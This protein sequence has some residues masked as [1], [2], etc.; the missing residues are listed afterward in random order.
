MARKDGSN[1]VTVAGHLS[2]PIPKLTQGENVTPV[3]G[4][5]N[6]AVACRGAAGA[7]GAF[8]VGDTVSVRY[9]VEKSNGDPWMLSE[10]S[11]GRIMIS[12][13]TFNYQRVIPEKNDV[14]SRSVENDDGSFTY[15]FADPLPAVYAAPYNDTASFGLDDGELTGQ[16]LLNGTYTVGMYMAWA[17]TVEGEGHRDSG[18][19]TADFLIGTGPLQSREVVAQDNCNQCHESLRAHGELRRDVKLCVLC[20]TAG[21]EDKNVGSAAGGTPGVSMDFKVMIHKIH[22]GAHLPS[23]LGVS[24]NPDGTRNYNAAPQPYQVVG[25]G[26]SVID[27]SHVK[28]PVWPSLNIAMP[29][30]AGYTAL[31]PTNRTKEDNIRLGVVACDK[32]HGT[33]T[34]P[35]R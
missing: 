1:G 13:P 30:D 23:V 8:Q 9:T 18:N 2:R 26:N 11:Y 31:S 10:F 28:F 3:H 20:H 17:Y 24:T 16:A 35:G 34:A 6:P 33:P 19:I 14:P 29:R 32:C 5:R 4:D 7:G 27:F 22:N 15:T 21:S 12:G 25:F